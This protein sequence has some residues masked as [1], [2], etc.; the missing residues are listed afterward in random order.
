MA[1]IANWIGMGPSNRAK[2][3]EQLPAR[4]KCLTG[5]RETA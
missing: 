1:E 2:V 5:E 4:L 3:S